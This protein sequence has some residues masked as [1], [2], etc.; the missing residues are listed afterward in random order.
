MSSKQQILVIL[1][2]GI[3]L[4]GGG[5]LFYRMVEQMTIMVGLL[6]RMTDNVTHMSADMRLMREEFHQL[7]GEVS[8][9][10][11]SVD[12]ME[13]HM[14]GM[15]QAFTQ[16]AKQMKQANPMQMMDGVFPGNR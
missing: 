13:T 5:G 14:A 12:K 16:G 3:A 15:A 7:G 11:T 4:I 10:G 2:L 9:I 8:G 1:V 6:E